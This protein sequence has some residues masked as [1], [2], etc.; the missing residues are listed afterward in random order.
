[1]IKRLITDEELSIAAAMVSDSMLRSLPEPEECTGVFTAQFEEKIEKLKKTATRKS[2]WKKY[3]Q[4]AVAAVLVFLIGFSMLCIFNTEVRAAVVT[5]VKET[6]KTYSTYWFTSEE[7]TELPVYELTWIPD[8]YEL[9]REDSYEQMYGAVYLRE[10]NIMDGFTFDYSIADND[11]QMTIQ[12]HYGQYHS[13]SV[14]I[15]V[16]YG[17]LYLSDNVNDANALIWFDEERSIMF[18]ITSYMDSEAI[19]H[20]ASNVKLVD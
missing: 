2:N 20:I 16:N 8:G 18:S 4:S 17:E 12:S 1:M 9:I 7:Q 19:L 14:N 11:T 10:N 15:G 6:F 5:W 13:E 3:L